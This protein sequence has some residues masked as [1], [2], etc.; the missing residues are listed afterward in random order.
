MAA[1]PDIPAQDGYGSVP[2][3]TDP[4]HLS[5]GYGVGSGSRPASYVASS[6]YNAAHGALEPSH[7]AHPTRFHEELDNNNDDYSQRNSTV[8]DGSSA[9]GLQRSDSHSSHAQSVSLSRGGTLRKKGSLSKRA[10]L[11]RSGSRKSLRAGSVR[12]LHLGDKEKYGVDGADN[13]NSP[14]FVPIPTN[15]SPTD[16]LANRFQGMWLVILPFRIDDTD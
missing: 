6:D 7:L 2:H 15:G 13:M 4:T 5:K 1:R 8:M 10:S 16:V 3:P 11:R 14:F 9:G 12:S